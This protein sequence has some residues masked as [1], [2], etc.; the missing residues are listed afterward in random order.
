MENTQ[1]Y[2]VENEEPGD[3][4]KLTKCQLERWRLPVVFQD[5]PLSVLEALGVRRL[6]GLNSQVVEV[7]RNG[8]VVTREL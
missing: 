6:R 7:D 5:L 3:W 1:L 2:T 4:L 8:E